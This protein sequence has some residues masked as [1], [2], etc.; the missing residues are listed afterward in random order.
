M[1]I[2]C[3]RVSRPFGH[4][5]PARAPRA[6][7][8]LRGPIITL[9]ALTVIAAGCGDNETEFTDPVH[10]QALMTTTTSDGSVRLYGAG[11]GDSTLRGWSVGDS[12]SLDQ[13]LWPGGD[14]DPVNVDTVGL[15]VTD[16]LF[17]IWGL[18]QTSSGAVVAASKLS[19]TIVVLSGGTGP[20][21]AIDSV[22]QGALVESIDSTI[23][24]TPARGLDRGGPIATQDGWIYSGGLDGLGLYTLTERLDYV[25]VAT[26]LGGADD[27]LAISTATPTPA[28]TGRVL[29]ARCR[30]RVVDAACLSATDE[31]ELIVAQRDSSGNLSVASRWTYQAAATDGRQTLLGD[32]SLAEVVNTDGSSMIVAAFE[33]SATV[34]GLQ[35]TAQES[36]DAVGTK[37][38]VAPWQDPLALPPFTA[39][40]VSTSTMAPLR[41]GQIAVLDQMVFV[42][43]RSGGF[44]AHFP[45][46]CLGQPVETEGCLAA[47]CL[48]EAGGCAGPSDASLTPT[49]PNAV[50]ASA[51]RVYVGLDVRNLDGTITSRIAILEVNDAGEVALVEIVDA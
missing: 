43:V 18:A 45:L 39:A 32:G 40:T 35:L 7:I 25:G 11:F 13:V 26:D 49:Y 33:G 24:L 42:A 27:L 1:S 44:V 10:L 8:G 12:L 2:T 51:S 46:T 31:A 21:R 36:L 22:T 28:G 23:G 48:D 29:V 30:G 16:G 19:G 41:S 14:V 4:A 3:A 37:R 47:T 20:L 5:A 9:G 38:V 34:I 50:T 17:G 6:R 15:T